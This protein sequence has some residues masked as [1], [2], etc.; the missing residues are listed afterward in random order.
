[1]YLSNRAKGLFCVASPNCE[2]V[3]Q[4]SIYEVELDTNLCDEMIDQAFPFWR[5][6]IFKKLCDI[7]Y[8]FSF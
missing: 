5:N 1:M 2:V 6:C 7:P 4:V 8:K 3:K